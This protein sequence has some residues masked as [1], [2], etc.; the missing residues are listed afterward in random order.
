MGSQAQ[1]RPG[2][3]VGGDFR[4]VSPLAEGGMGAVYL[5][6]QQSTGKRRALKVMHLAI[7]DDQASIQRFV[8]EAQ[9]GSR[10]ESEHVVEVIAAGLDAESG[11]PWLAMELLEG[12]SLASIVEQ[13]GR[14]PPADLLRVYQQIAHA[15]SA[16]HRAGIVHRDLK[17]ENVFVAA[18]RRSD[19]PFTVKLLDFGI[20][21]L[22]ASATSAH[23]SQLIGS[24]LWMAPEQLQPNAPI[25][26]ATDV[27]ALGLIAF[28]LLTGRFYWVA[29]NQQD[30]GLQM[31]I[32]EMVVSPIVPASERA[33]ALGVGGVL[34]GGFDAWFA[35]TVVRD[36]AGRFASVDELMAALPAALEGVARSVAAS[37][38]GSAPAPWVA[39]VAAQQPPQQQPPQPQIVSRPQLAATQAGPGL[40]TGP[41]ASP[42]PHTVLSAPASLARTPPPVSA[43]QPVA[44]PRR[45]SA[46][47]VLGGGVALLGVV[48][49]AAVG[50]VGTR[51]HDDGASVGVDAPSRAP[52]A[53]QTSG[54][55]TSGALARAAAPEVAPQPATTVPPSPGAVAPSAADDGGLAAREETTPAPGS[56]APPTEPSARERPR[57]SSSSRGTSSP[58]GGT[59]GGGVSGA[60]TRTDLPETP[61][62]ADVNRAVA[63]VTPSMRAC[64]TGGEG[65]IRMTV[66][67]GSDGRVLASQSSLSGSLVASGA[68]IQAA[69]AR[70]RVPPFSRPRF[71]VTYPIRIYTSPATSSSGGGSTSTSAPAGGSCAA[72]DCACI[73][74]QPAQSQ[75]A[76]EMRI[77][78][79]RQQGNH[80]RAQ[81]DMRTYLARYPTGPRANAFRQILG[82]Q[83]GG[84]SGGGAR[85]TGVPNNPF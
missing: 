60:P 56:S 65:S 45:G 68:C 41:A 11:L 70:M 82:Q 43:T 24:P 62:S 63:S 78:C 52:V 4:I 35:R 42:L 72:G 31:L 38:A 18:S 21:K 64:V 67:F 15:L 76:L 37:P 16:A 66:T 81:A 39:T 61:S 50:Y 49:V 3:I 53:T 75:R 1:L 80:S 69:A 30:V 33:A 14:M 20:A 17:P 51:D 22:V 8:R 2:R 57:D 59:T 44:E 19:A 27:W 54:A 5:A 83:G 77:A 28:Y 10:I 9:V 36:A 13:R 34:P 26:P 32:A 23:N 58:G 6:E 55:I 85:S 48:A 25:G 84:S 47:R 12:G 40:A 79:F 71:S 7:A 46:L 73:V 74:R 29:A